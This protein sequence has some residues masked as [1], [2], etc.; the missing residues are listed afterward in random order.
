MEGIQSLTR[1]YLSDVE[2]KYEIR[3]VNP[4]QVFEILSSSLTRENPT[5][6]KYNYSNTGVK[7]IIGMSELD[8]RWTSNFIG[9]INCESTQ[10]IISATA[11]SNGSHIP[12]ADAAIGPYSWSYPSRRYESWEVLSSIKYLDGCRIASQ[13]IMY[14]TSSVNYLTED[15]FAHS[16]WRFF[17]DFYAGVPTP[18]Q[19]I[20]YGTGNKRAWGYSGTN[21]RVTRSHQTGCGGSTPITVTTQDGILF[22]G[23]MVPVHSGIATAW[24]TFKE[25]CG[26]CKLSIDLCYS[27]AVVSSDCLRSPNAVKAEDQIPII[28]ARQFTT[29]PFSVKAG[30]VNSV[31]VSSQT[32]PMENSKQETVTVH[33]SDRFSVTVG[34]YQLIDNRA[35]HATS[36]R[37]EVDVQIRSIWNPSFNPNGELLKYGNGGFL[38]SHVGSSCGDLNIENHNFITKK[39]SSGNVQF[40]FTYTKTCSQCL[41]WVYY[42]I[43]TPSGNQ[44]WSSFPLRHR[45][46]DSIYKIT[47]LTCAALW[48]VPPNIRRTVVAGE[49][50][51]MSL[52]KVNYGGHP[53]WDGY[54]LFSFTVQH[55]YGNG[56]GGLFIISSPI[57]VGSNNKVAAAFGVLTVRLLFTRSCFLCVIAA[58]WDGGVIYFPI[59]VVEQP[60]S[61]K[62]IFSSNSGSYTSEV[63]KYTVTHYASNMYGDRAVL[64]GGPTV[65]NRQ[66]FDLTSRTE[67]VHSQVTERR[68][69]Q[70][71]V[72]DESGRG[73]HLINITALNISFNGGELIFWDGVGLQHVTDRNTT[74]T[75]SDFTTTTVFEISSGTHNNGSVIPAGGVSKQSMSVLNNDN[76]LIFVTVPVTGVKL[77]IYSDSESVSNSGIVLSPGVPTDYVILLLDEFNRI[78][79][80]TDVTLFSIDSSA[81]STNSSSIP[82]NGCGF[83]RVSSMMWMRLTNVYDGDND[84]IGLRLE[85][86]LAVGHDSDCY[87]HVSVSYYENGKTVSSLVI[88]V[89][90]RPPSEVVLTWSVPES[91]AGSTFMINHQI[92]FKLLLVDS[93]SRKLATPTIIGSIKLISEP[94]NC[95]KMTQSTSV[96]GGFVISG[97]FVFVTGDV[98]SIINSV[99]IHPSMLL[100]NSQPFLFRVSTFDYNAESGIGLFVPPEQRHF[101]RELFPIRL[102]EGLK[103]IAGVISPV[104]VVGRFVGVLFEKFVASNLTQT[105]KCVSLHAT[106]INTSVSSN[107]S[108]LL[109][110]TI[111]V[112]GNYSCQLDI[113]AVT[114]S[115]LLS[116]STEVESFVAIV[117]PSDVTISFL[118]HFGTPRE[119]SL[120][121]DEFKHKPYAWVA[122]YQLSL[123]VKVVGTDGKGYF[124]KEEMLRKV[125]FRTQSIP[126]L[127]GWED[128]F[129]NHCGKIGNYISGTCSILNNSILQSSPPHGCE[130]MFWGTTTIQLNSSGEGLVKLIHSG[131]YNMKEIPILSNIQVSLERYITTPLGDGVITLPIKIDR[132]RLLTLDCLYCNQAERP[133]IPEGRYPVDISVLLKDE[134]GKIVVADSD[135]ILQIRA[136]CGGQPH[137]VSLVIVSGIGGRELIQ[138]NTS[139]SGWYDLPTNRGKGIL[140][141]ASFTG[142]CYDGAI[143]ARCLLDGEI[144]RFGWCSDLR[145][146]L[147]VSFGNWSVK[148]PPTTSAPMSSNPVVQVTLWGISQS[149]FDE[150]EFSAKLGLDLIGALQTSVSVVV[151]YLCRVILEKGS[152]IPITDN[153]RLNSSICKVFD[154]SSGSHSRFV[155]SLTTTN[156]TFIVEFEVQSAGDVV[157]DADFTSAVQTVLETPGNTIRTAYPG[158]ATQPLFVILPTSVPTGVPTYA[159]TDVPISTNA[160]NQITD[161]PFVSVSTPIPTIE[162]I[163]VPSTAS[164]LKNVS[165]VSSVVCLLL[166]TLI[167]T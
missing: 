149:T 106:V 163:P 18:I 110:V 60:V 31:L 64:Y 15:R 63:N 91:A 54:D 30:N 72:Y 122:G 13:S 125:M 134:F 28:A 166:F 14:P 45:E 107:G 162:I 2:I 135:S 12:I 159:A 98:C 80:V 156:Y 108:L 39:A 133:Q 112:S 121:A 33:T 53:S 102:T 148:P 144:D 55:R 57:V 117:L 29:S 20:I 52:W 83:T 84:Q 146:V 75:G 147:N 56:E 79:V 21:I 61:I 74:L 139:V 1:Y 96:K 43:K 46:T 128:T 157:T 104:A 123:F 153:D 105:L 165:E 118:T 87:C 27:T 129:N 93:A 97:Y 38:S 99:G 155:H 19:I 16:G 127:E 26:E 113:Q 58:S 51:T 42:K 140:P 69:S 22:P 24:V 48:V 71:G 35:I 167:I 76:K 88:P 25:P 77:G 8:G 81:C 152:P 137:S 160:S 101:H 100:L 130:D 47:V 115:G 23:G 32:L 6:E 82:G 114:K 145:F 143:E 124:P 68:S 73:F 10:L 94:K 109:G 17:D 85:S 7:T 161:I 138:K 89:L 44:Q 111:P 65:P 150:Q 37:I 142:S 78:S 66:R 70:I 132:I 4:L 131:G 49:Y 126:C 95:F 90:L 119:R 92:S 62:S 36:S 67:P 136:T 11:T 103:S 141:N 151:R 86:N 164:L 154:S 59:T 116:V 9:K 40:E 41:L 120:S 158:L 50:F 34:L 5:S 3:S